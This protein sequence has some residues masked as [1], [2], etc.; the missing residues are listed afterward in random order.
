MSDALER[1]ERLTE[2]INELRISVEKLLATNAERCPT[3]LRQI[4]SHDKSLDESFT[5]LR[6][7][8]KNQG[9]TLESVDKL[10]RALE[11]QTTNLSET[12]QTVA[13]LAQNTEQLQEM[14]RN[15]AVKIDRIFWYIALTVGAATALQFV[16]NKLW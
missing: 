10:T 11:K 9:V 15:H 7:V 3:R 4:E 8:E 13:K 16:V 6:S 12:Q 5:R 14:T 1:V 2:Q